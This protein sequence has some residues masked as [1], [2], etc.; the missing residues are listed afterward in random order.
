MIETQSTQPVSALA[1]ARESVPGTIVDSA[2]QSAR[3]AHFG[4]ALRALLRS[5][6]AVVGLLIV[7]FWV[8]CAVFWPLLVRYDPNAQDYTAIL[9]HPS[10]AHLLGRAC[11][12]AAARCS[13]WPPRRRS[14]AL[15][16]ASW[17]GS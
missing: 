17:W 9:A 14:S 3:P 4:V 2:G 5:P 13:S 1:G 15:S 12:L 8:L 10:A 16:E 11:L 6:S 7:L